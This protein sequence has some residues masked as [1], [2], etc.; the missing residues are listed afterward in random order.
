MHHSRCM[1]RSEWEKAM[2]GLHEQEL[3]LF[4]RRAHRQLGRGFVLADSDEGQPVYITWIIGA[5]PPLIEAVFAYDPERETV[6]VSQDGADEGNIM[7]N[8]VR[9][10]HRH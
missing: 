5:P 2:Q 7:I 10:E 4:G 1:K 8:Y 9:I 6:V 3:A